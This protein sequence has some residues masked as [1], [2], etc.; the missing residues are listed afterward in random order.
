MVFPRT[1]LTVARYDDD[2]DDDDDDD[3]RPPVVWPDR[4]FAE[5]APDAAN[6]YLAMNPSPTKR[7]LWDLFNGADPSDVILKFPEVEIEDLADSVGGW[8]SLR[9]GGYVA[10]YLRL[11]GAQRRQLGREADILVSKITKLRFLGRS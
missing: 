2:D 1:L 3:G 6:D 11:T 4:Y 5:L 9:V 10:F 8:S 7:A